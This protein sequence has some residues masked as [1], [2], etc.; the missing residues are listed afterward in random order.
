MG[1][2]QAVRKKIYS[3]TTS[4]LT[5]PLLCELINA[6]NDNIAKLFSAIA[7]LQSQLNSGLDSLKVKVQDS[8]NCPGFLKDKLVNSDTITIQEVDTNGCKTLKFNVVP[9]AST[10]TSPTP[11]LVSACKTNWT[12]QTSYEILQGDWQVNPGVPNKQLQGDVEWSIDELSKVHLRGKVFA[13]GAYFYFDIND[14]WNK[15]TA[16]IFELPAEQCL[17]DLLDNTSDNYGANLIINGKYAPGSGANQNQFAPWKMHT[18]LYR[19]GRSFYVDF[20]QLES[21]AALAGHAVYYDI[22]IAFGHLKSIN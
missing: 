11:L 2:L 17:K 22:V 15:R 4:V 13:N 8:D 3:V 14:E 18:E 6:L 20:R 9:A 19:V 21:V 1:L 10:G 7:D 5:D 16:L 12:A